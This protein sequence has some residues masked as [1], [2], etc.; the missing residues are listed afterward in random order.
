M[1]PALSPA[2]TLVFQG[3][4]LFKHLCGEHTRASWALEFWRHIQVRRNDAAF[5]SEVESVAASEPRA[6]LA[7]GA[8]TSLAMLVFGQ[9]APE[10]LT[11]WTTDRLPSRVRQWVETYGRRVLLS[12]TAGSKLYLILREQ[13]EVGRV[14]KATVRRLMFPTH[15]PPPITHGEPGERLMRRLERYCIESR[16]MCWR[17]RFHV[18]EGVNY[19][20][21]SSRW[22]RRIAR[23]SQ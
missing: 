15:L 22:G 10:A 12:G 20:I 14:S 8:A 18:V 5:W 17:L 23:T 11:R 1:I 4:H 19:A 21:E 3:Q 7:L 13:L 2:D 16:H 6:D 9:T